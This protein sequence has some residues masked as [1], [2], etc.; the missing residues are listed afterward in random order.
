MEQ[1][2]SDKRRLA[3][4]ATRERLL[5]AAERVFA[6]KGYDGAGTRELAEAAGADVAMIVYHFGSK[7]GLYRE[8]MTRRARPL[9]D[10]RL[11]ELDRVLE[12]SKGR[13]ELADVIHALV[14]SNI[15][16]RSD[17]EMGGLPVARLIAREMIDPEQPDRHT[18]AEMF[19]TLAAR[20]VAAIKLAL[21]GTED[22][23][24]YWAYHFAISAMVQTMANVGRLEELSGN[25]CDMSDSERVIEHLVPFIVA[26]VRA[27]AQLPGIATPA[28]RKAVAAKGA[29]RPVRAA[30]KTTQRAR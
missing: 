20:F 6:Q 26:G 23:P 28:P 25:V 15:R 22:E 17:P 7:L 13:P 18:I 29:K 14:A 12:A 4:E 19:D 2:R 16:M 3:G 8:V 30:A 10:K 11:A 24:L 5:S 9:N 1:T 27:C 21:P